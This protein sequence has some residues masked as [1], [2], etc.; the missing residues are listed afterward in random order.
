[1][2]Y[3]AT[4]VPNGQSE[5]EVAAT[6]HDNDPNSLWADLCGQYERVK[7]ELEGLGGQLGTEDFAD[8]LLAA[9][10]RIV[11]RLT[12]HR[13]RTRHQIAQK[14]KVA[15]TLMDEADG[16]GDSAR[17]LLESAAEDLLR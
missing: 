9:Q 16:D 6:F 2:S 15:L 12:T 14:L 10:E 7:L 5:S 1:M 8:A 17:L 4:F 3:D 13:V 11:A